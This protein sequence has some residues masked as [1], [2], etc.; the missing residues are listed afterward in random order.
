MQE[1]RPYPTVIT[2]VG[3]L[4]RK[5]KEICDDLLTLQPVLSIMIYAME[6]K[7]SNLTLNHRVFMAGEGLSVRT[8]GLLWSL[9]APRPPF[10]KAICYEIQR[11]RRTHA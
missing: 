6:S 3:L 9:I 7:E 5:I 4:E 11:K 1:V 10:L 2:I 8:T